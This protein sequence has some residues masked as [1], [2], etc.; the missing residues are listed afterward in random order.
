MCQC[1]PRGLTGSN[2]AV[3][4]SRRAVP[5]YSAWPWHDD[6]RAASARR[7]RKERQ[8]RRCAWTLHPPPAV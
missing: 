2:S 1:S 7:R 6:H 3:L 8:Q 5:C 4:N